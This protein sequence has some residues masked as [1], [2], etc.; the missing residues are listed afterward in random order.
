MI[1]IFMVL[2]NH[3]NIFMVLDNHRN[4]FMMLDNHRK[5]S[6]YIHGVR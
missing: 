5:S 6:K 3:R 1:K 4:I 2:D